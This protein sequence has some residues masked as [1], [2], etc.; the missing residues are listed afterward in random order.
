M[1]KYSASFAAEARFGIP[2]LARA[3]LPFDLDFD[4]LGLG[5]FRKG[6]RQDAVLTYRFDLALV[7][8][9][10]QSQLAPEAA[11]GALNMVVT[12]LVLIKSPCFTFHQIALSSNSTIAKCVPN[13]RPT[14]VA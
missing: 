5:C 10:R 3:L 8:V 7:Y 4:R 6:H 11:V 9:G 13:S 14:L 12:L 2:G 1:L